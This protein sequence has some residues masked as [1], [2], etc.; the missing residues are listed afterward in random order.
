MTSSI[1]RLL[2]D[3]AIGLEFCLCTILSFGRDVGFS[4][5]VSQTGMIPTSIRFEEVLVA[6][7]KGK[8]LNS[9]TVYTYRS[10]DGVYVKRTLLS[11]RSVAQASAEFDRTVKKAIKVI[12]HSNPASPGHKGV[13]RRYVVL[14]RKGGVKE[15]EAAIL[16]T[17]GVDFY[18]LQSKSLKHALALEKQIGQ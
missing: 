11:Y 13:G 16:W 17:S 15:T 3:I 12:E 9:G 18:E 2:V 7:I 5:E 10:E 6:D 14:L 4:V 1:L 8:N